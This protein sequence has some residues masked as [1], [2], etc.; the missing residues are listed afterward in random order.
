MKA[1]NKSRQPVRATAS[2][3][4][5]EDRSLSGIVSNHSDALPTNA[6]PMRNL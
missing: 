3:K 2:S 6:I 1:Q 5:G 4:S